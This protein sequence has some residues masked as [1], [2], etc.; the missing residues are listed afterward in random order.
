MSASDFEQYDLLIDS[1]SYHED[2]EE[3]LGYRDDGDAPA[4]SHAKGNKKK[5]GKHKPVNSSAE[6]GDSAGG[7]NH[8][9]SEQ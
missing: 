1:L 4:P 9:K 6:D 5:G 7:G 8:H 3:D 2:E